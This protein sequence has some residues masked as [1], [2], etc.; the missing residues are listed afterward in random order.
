MDSALLGWTRNQWTAMPDEFCC[1]QAHVNVPSRFKV[2]SR[3]KEPRKYDGMPPKTQDSVYHAKEEKKKT[4]VEPLVE[5][6][7][8]FP[9]HPSSPLGFFFSF[10]LRWYLVLLPRPECSGT[11]SAHCDLQLPGS[12]DFCAS[13]SQVA[14]TTGTCYHTQLFF[15]FLVETGFCH[16]AQAGLELL[17]SSDLSASVSQSAGM[18][19]VSHRTQP[20]WLL[21]PSSTSQSVT[22]KSRGSSGSVQDSRVSSPGA[23]GWEGGEGQEWTRWGFALVPQAA[24]QWRDLGSLQPPPTGFKHF[25]CLSLLSSWDYRLLPPCL[26]K[27][28]FHHIGQAGLELLTSGDPPTS[29]SQRV[30]IT[31]VSHLAYPKL[32]FLK[33]YPIT[34]LSKGDVYKAPTPSKETQGALEVKEDGNVQ[35]EVPVDQMG[36]LSLCR[37]ACGPRVRPALVHGGRWAPFPPPGRREE[38]GAGF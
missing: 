7:A 24:V 10:I 36:M 38:R 1:L 6:G 4:L 20:A 26:A 29:A 11:I 9:K 22:R 32:H 21:L 19:G 37:S 33:I 18:T 8:G 14:G 3:G 28:G 5:R 15:V 27:M 16:V 34:L 30:G 23:E 35:L 17:I 2:D 25:S 13:A 12:S 31:G